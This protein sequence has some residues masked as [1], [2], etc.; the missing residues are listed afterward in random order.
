MVALT[1]KTPANTFKDLLQV[2]NTNSG[3]DATLRD[4]SDGEGTTS[5][6]KLS[7]LAASFSGTMAITGVTTF[8]DDVVSD[9]DSTDDLGTTGVRWANLWVD[10]ITVTTSITSGSVAVNDIGSATS[11]TF[12]LDAD[13]T[14]AGTGIYGPNAT[15]ASQINFTIDGVLAA[16]FDENLFFEMISAGSPRILLQD[17]TNDCKGYMQAGDTFVAMGTLS[18]HNLAIRVNGVSAIT[19][20]D[21]SR[22]CAFESTTDSTT[23]TTGSIQTDGGLGVVKTIVAGTGIKLGGTAAAN[24]LADYEEGNF[25]PTLAFGGASVGLTYGTQFGTYTKVGNRV[26]GTINI[27]LTAKGSSTG[28]AIISGL[29]FTSDS[30]AGNDTAIAIRVHNLQS[31]VGGPQGYV[32][33]NSATINL[34][35]S[36]TG[37]RGVMNEGDFTNTAQLYI[38]FDYEV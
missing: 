19:I 25:T 10:D 22:D 38:Q 5:S 6:M 24:L 11:P 4:V 33:S 13:G 16:S 17:T 18:A 30:T 31:L 15:G 28:N 34:E 29:P 2:S 1:G 23:T 35:F 37:T 36:D 20:D 7:T 26:K 27:I 9:T 21:T 3:V 12:A 8:G 32:P 14:G